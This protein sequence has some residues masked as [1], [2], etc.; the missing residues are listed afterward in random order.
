MK[1]KSVEGT[2][3]SAGKG[4]WRIGDEQLKS[5]TVLELFLS[6][7]WLIGFVRRSSDSICRFRCWEERVTISLRPGLRVRALMPVLE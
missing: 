3:K 6:G 5:G 2:L 1:I 7:R 4:S